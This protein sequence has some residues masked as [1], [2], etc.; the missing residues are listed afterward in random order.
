VPPVTLI[1]DALQLAERQLCD[2]FWAGDA[3]MTPSLPGLLSSL[4]LDPLL[5]WL[6]ECEIL[7]NDNDL[8]EDM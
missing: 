5:L 4:P 6:W 1:I 7:D 2:A 3:G 8:K